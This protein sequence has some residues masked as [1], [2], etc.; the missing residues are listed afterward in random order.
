[1]KRVK[2]INKYI[3][4]ISSESYNLIGLSIVRV[5]IGI[6]SLIMLVANF[7]T[8]YDLW[9]DS[10]FNSTFLNFNHTTFDI[11]YSLIVISL[12]VYILGFESIVFNVFIYIS[13]YFL[14]NLNNYILDG[15][16]NILI[17]ILFYMIFTKNAQYFSIYKGKNNSQF[18]NSIHNIFLFL[19]LFQVCV[20]YFF[21]GFAKAR[22]DF[23][24]SGVAPYYVFQIKT[25]T[26]GWI[27]NI[28]EPFIKSPLILLIISYSAIFMQMLFPI[29]IFNKIT[30]VLVVIGSITFHLSIIAVMGL[31][32]FGM[33]MIALDLLFINDQQFI[34]LKKFITKRRESFLN[35]KSNYI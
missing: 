20:L 29:L 19:I 33:I 9:S 14:Y 7:Q 12:I 17:I 32:T 11:F 4:F 2:Q 25:F 13:M 26:M 18:R 5:A 1:M 31:V 30:K 34:K 23:W 8:R 3:S 15:G 21:A 28:I 6:V 16:N 10:I 27:D 22:G 24:Y 35:Q